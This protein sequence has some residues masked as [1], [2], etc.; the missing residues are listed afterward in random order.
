MQCMYPPIGC[1]LDWLYKVR[2][3][4]PGTGPQ[5]VGEQSLKNTFT[6]LLILAFSLLVS[7][8]LRH[9]HVNY[10]NPTASGS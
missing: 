6:S 7:L 5:A 8:I 3:L 4:H 1:S 9:L 10:K 2:G